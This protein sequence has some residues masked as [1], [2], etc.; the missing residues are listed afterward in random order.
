M[1]THGL[2]HNN[3][4]SDSATGKHQ[5]RPLT[6]RL[7]ALHGSPASVAS[8]LGRSLPPA[9]HRTRRG[10]QGSL[11]ALGLKAIFLATLLGLLRLPAHRFRL[12][13]TMLGASWEAP[14]KTAA[15]AACASNWVSQRAP[16]CASPGCLWA[17]EV[18][19]AWMNRWLGGLDT[20]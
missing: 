7:E 16:V 2:R 8:G 14:S 10:G 3:N 15:G 11:E 12:D 4:Q 20:K 17:S 6:G 18:G 19:H 5:A 13:Y 9:L 1:I